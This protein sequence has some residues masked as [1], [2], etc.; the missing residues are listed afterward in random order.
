MSGRGSSL[1][2]IPCHG[3]KQLVMKKPNNAKG[4]FSLQLNRR[5]NIELQ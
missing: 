3:K 1:M 2:K 4:M 5:V